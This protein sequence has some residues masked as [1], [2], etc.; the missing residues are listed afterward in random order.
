M[1]PRKESGASE[2]GVAGSA[3][4]HNFR[5]I[6]KSPL[7]GTEVTETSPVLWLRDTE[8]QPFDLTVQTG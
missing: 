1:G 6:N 7:T 8:V 3:Q 5:P 4:A 2:N